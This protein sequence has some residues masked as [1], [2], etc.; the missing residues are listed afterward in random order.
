MCPYSGGGSGWP[1]TQTGRDSLERVA[2]GWMCDRG[3]LPLG[4][5]DAL[6]TRTHAAAPRVPQQHMGMQ[7][8]QQQVCAC[9]IV[10]G[11]VARPGRVVKPPLG[12]G[13]LDGRLVPASILGR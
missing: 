2:A 6:S 12:G 7:Q 9:N 10:T 4:P 13:G 8:Q 11:I 1:Q 5:Y 3:L